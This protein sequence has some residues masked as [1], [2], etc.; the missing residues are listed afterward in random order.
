MPW[1]SIGAAVGGKI[2]GSAFGRHDAK[3]GAQ[4][5]QRYSR[6]MEND[7]WDDAQD[8]GLTAQEYYGS[9]APGGPGSSGAG[10]VIGNQ[11]DK[12]AQQMS[13]ISQE[14]KER[15]KDR[16]VQILGQ[17]NQLEIAKTQAGETRHSTDTNAQT[18][19]K[20]LAV[21]KDELESVIKPKAAA[22]LNI[23][24]A[25]FEQKLNEVITSQPQ[26]HLM[27]KRLTMGPDNLFVEA[28]IKS[29]GIDPTEDDA[30][31]NIPAAKRK[32]F[33]DGLIAYKSSTAGEIS[34]LAR[35]FNLNEGSNPSNPKNSLGKP[36]KTVHKNPLFTI[37]KH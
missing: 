6:R 14:T 31:N 10:Q 12:M 29:T 35:Y 4:I 33:L 21:K 9:S 16:K 32:A 13:A 19:A 22:E 15:D 7:R 28:Y 8:R 25:A 26:W 37:K 1:S 30:F 36:G 5:D 18:A 20:A 24:R 11:G 17:Q 23:S 2:L 27:M 3:S 34:G